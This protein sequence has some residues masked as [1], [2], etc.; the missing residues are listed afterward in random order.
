MSSCC[1]KSLKQRWEEGAPCGVGWLW[2]TTAPGHEHWNRSS[3]V[4]MEVPSLVWAARTVTEMNS[5]P[6]PNMKPLALFVVS[7]FLRA[8]LGSCQHCGKK[9][10]YCVRGC[11]YL[12]TYVHYLIES[13][14]NPMQWE[15]VLPQFT[16]EE[17]DTEW[18][19]SLIGVTEPPRREPEFETRVVQPRIPNLH[20]LYSAAGFIKYHRRL[21]G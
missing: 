3:L 11:H 2:D 20:P 17:T 4:R 21:R 5:S 19:S 7:A 8:V 15:P 18:I 14:N 10:F 6:N 13:C 12:E 16:D 1:V 9:Y